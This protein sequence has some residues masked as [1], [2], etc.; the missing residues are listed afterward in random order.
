MNERHVQ[1][2]HSSPSTK[3]LITQSQYEELHVFGLEIQCYA[4]S[5]N[6]FLGQSRR[7]DSQPRTLM[8]CS[9]Y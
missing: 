4:L 9:V 3:M 8:K 6:I 7:E 2:R 1:S 5:F